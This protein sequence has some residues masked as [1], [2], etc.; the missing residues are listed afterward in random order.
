MKIFA[1]NH[2]FHLSKENYE[3]LECRIDKDK[4]DEIF[5]IV[6]I[7]KEHKSFD[8]I[9]TTLSKVAAAALSI[10]INQAWANNTPAFD[11]KQ[12]SKIYMRMPYSM[13]FQLYF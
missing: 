5:Y 8:L 10:A 9:A 3:A 6:A 12:W 1:D 13:I 7:H 2:I 11:I 4:D